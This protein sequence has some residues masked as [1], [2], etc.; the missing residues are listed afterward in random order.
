MTFY[1]NRNQKDTYVCR[2]HRFRLH[3]HLL[4]M[5]T[6]I[7]TPVYT[8]LYTHTCIHIPVYISHAHLHPHLYTHAPYM[9]VWLVGT[10]IP[11]GM[12]MHFL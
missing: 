11:S 12:L 1:L 9:H 3:I 10:C 7:H 4:I 6:C 8:H 5:N 2:L